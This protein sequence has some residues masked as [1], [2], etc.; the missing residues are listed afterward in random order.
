MG[1]PE[2]SRL[3]RVAVSTD[4]HPGHQDSPLR[5]MDQRWTRIKIPRIL[6]LPGNHHGPGFFPRKFLTQV[7]SH[8]RW[9]V[10]HQVRIT[11]LLRLKSLERCFN[12]RNRSSGTSNSSDQ[13]KKRRQ[14]G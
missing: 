4:Q 11:R 12:R 5:R 8:A 1:Q 3:T 7:C 6:D 2:Q 14:Q 13:K 9:C 10:L